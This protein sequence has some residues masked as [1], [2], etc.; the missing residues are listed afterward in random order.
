MS[1]PID[2][3][4]DFI[5]YIE[6]EG[7]YDEFDPET[8]RMRT[9]AGVEALIKEAYSYM[10]EK[11]K[12]GEAMARMRDLTDAQRNKLIEDAEA[13]RVID[14]RKEFQLKMS[15]NGGAQGIVER[16]VNVLDSGSPQDINNILADAQAF[17]KGPENVEKK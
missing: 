7:I 5:R 15:R 14:L 1:R 6:N 12:A 10:P 8:Q 9:S 13:D 2:F 3:I 11:L 17:V 4:R 16:L